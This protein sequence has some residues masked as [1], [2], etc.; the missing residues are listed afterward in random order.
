MDNDKNNNNNNENDKINFIVKNEEEDYYDY[1]EIHSYNNN[2]NKDDDNSKR[3][4][5]RGYPSYFLVALVAAV[6]GGLISSLL[7]PAL[8]GG[9][10]GIY[11]GNTEKIN[12]TSSESIS[13]VEAVAKKSM[14][15]VVGVTTT[16]TI[17]D[18]FFGEKQVQGVGS[19]II[20]DSKGYILTNSHVVGNGAAEN[21]T[22]MFE[23]GDKKSAKVMWFENALDL[24]VIKV[25][26]ANYP[27]A[28]IGNSDSLNIGE[29]AVAIG[30]PLG[31]DFERTVTSGII[32]GLNRTVQ[33]D[34][35]TKVENLIQTNAAINSGNSGGPLLNGR[36]E[37]IGIN[38]LKLKSA[39]GLGFAIPINIVKPIID[40]VIKEGKYTS[41]YIGIGGDSVAKYRAAGIDVG[42]ESGIVVSQVE[43]GSPADKAGISKMNI[44]V[45]LNGKEIDSLET[46]RKE[47]YKYKPGEKVKIGVI[48]ED[49]KLD[50]DLTLGEKKD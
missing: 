40:Q 12:I 11:S 44:I 28:D 15:S 45:S 27:A 49:K 32:S 7:V 17:R 9:K 43:A 22:V 2:N 46:L 41:V 26:G 24:A 36:G 19:G 18:V 8:I 5:R 39:E 35:Y 20:I 14:K 33:A 38:T 21:I 13:P 30:N 4:K 37:V 34:Q 42:V 23:N 50:I 25:E 31:L 6:I 29:L 3:E 16:E 48:K 1:G 47:M 10:G